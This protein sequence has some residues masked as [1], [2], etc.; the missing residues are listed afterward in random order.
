M[1]LVNV[2]L[3]PIFAGCL[4][5]QTSAQTSQTQTTT[6]TTTS[7]ATDPVDLNGTLVDQSCYTTHTQ[8]KETNSDQNSTTTT[9]TNKTST[10]CPV[11]AS[12]TAFS[13]LTPDGKIVRFDD[14]SNTRVVEMM[15]SDRDFSDE[16]N[17]HR[18]VKVRVVAMRNGDVMVVKEIKADR[19]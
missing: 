14:A 3:I 8:T 15:R 12:T 13:L 18:P 9:V 4:L 10:D 11:T 5:A 7:G 17:R 19:Q 6:T 1:K 2:C 16:I